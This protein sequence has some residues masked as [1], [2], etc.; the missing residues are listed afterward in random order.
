MADKMVMKL[1]DRMQEVVQLHDADLDQTVLG[2]PGP[3]AIQTARISPVFALPGPAKAPPRPQNVRAPTP[4][5]RRFGE[6]EPEHRQGQYKDTVPMKVSEDQEEIM[7]ALSKPEMWTAMAKASEA[8]ANGATEPN[9]V[10]Y[11]F[12]FFVHGGEFGEMENLGEANREY[13]QHRI[14]TALE[15]SKDPGNAIQSVDVRL[16][17]EGKEPKTY[18]LEVIVKKQ[19]GTIVLSNPR[20]AEHSFAE[21]VDHMHDTLKTKMRKEKDKFIAKKKHERQKGER[22][23][24]AEGAAEGEGEEDLAVGSPEGR[25]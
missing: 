11:S 22:Q 9:E 8:L 13:L 3:M 18:M 6:P 5:S 15:N 23:G 1:F 14:E 4:P 24:F 10:P 20:N 17:I 25:P 19:F 12:N 16:N 7:N 21:A 2:K